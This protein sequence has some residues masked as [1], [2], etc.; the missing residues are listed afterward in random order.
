M[1]LHISKTVPEVIVALADYI[2]NVTQESIAERG[3]C[4][5][6]LSGGSSPELLYKMLASAQYRKQLNWDKMNFFFGDER[7][8]PSHDAQNNANM[9]KRAMFDP[10]N[11]SPAQIFP[12]NTALPP[13]KA[14]KE[15]SEQIAKH[16]KGK[17]IIFDLILLGLGDNSHTASLFPYTLILHDQ[18]V[19]VQ[20]VFLKEQNV[21]RISM[22]APMI[23]LARHIAFLVYGQGKAEAVRH[24]LEDEANIE[25]YP[26]QLI[27]PKHGIVKWYLD[28]A[29]AMLLK[30]E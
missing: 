11:I 22:T 24:V 29:A 4:N 30:S 23:N 20:S 2:V 25:E 8:V 1:T 10:L 19:S 16:F 12:V 21:Y 15:Y 28:E 14:A 18:S 3:E 17:E 6:V 26:A 13:N 7:N 9:V 5:V 27:I